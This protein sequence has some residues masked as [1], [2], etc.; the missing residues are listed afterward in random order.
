M[1]K[2]DVWGK[3]KSLNANLDLLRRCTDPYFE[4]I[5]TY[6]EKNHLSFEKKRTLLKILDYYMVLAY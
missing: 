3:A 5:Q 2:R 1:A 4:E 6:A